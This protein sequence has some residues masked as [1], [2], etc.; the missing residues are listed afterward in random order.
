MYIVCMSCSYVSRNS[1]RLSFPQALV[2]RYLARK[3]SEFALLFYL[4]G[5]Q[6]PV[7]TVAAD[8]AVS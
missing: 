1:C 4:A 2:H 8:G 3:L 7:T 6:H 5:L